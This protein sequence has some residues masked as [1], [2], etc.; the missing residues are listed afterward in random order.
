MTPLGEAALKL[1]AK[2]LRVFPCWP[3][4]KEPAI[5]DNLRLA[6]VDEAII[7]RFWGEQGTYNIGIAT[8]R[9]S[10][11][12]VLDIDADHGGEQTLREL[13]A[14]RGALP[15]TVEAITGAGRH[16]Y[17]AGR[18]GSTSATPRF[19][20]TCPASIGEAKAASRS[21]RR[22]FIRAGAFMR[23]PSTR[24]PNSP[25]RRDG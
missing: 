4:R 16:L 24:P 17:G 2:G 18:T 5:K 11:I 21:P 12:W 20:T 22:A 15:P 8:G 13:E 9:A 7:R 1:G 3:R 6:A 14:K 10:G 23:G 25:P 19:A